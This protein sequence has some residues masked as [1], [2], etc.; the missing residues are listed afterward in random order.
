MLDAYSDW[1]DLFQTMSTPGTNGNVT[2]TINEN[3]RVSLVD[4]GLS[5]RYMIQDP[6]TGE[7]SHIPCEKINRTLGNK[8]FMSLNQLKKYGKLELC[9]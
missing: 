1:A 7:W 9:S 5:E 8:F 3:A 2:V 4:F 6:Q